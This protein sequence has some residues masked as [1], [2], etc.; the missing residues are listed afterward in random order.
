MV[1]TLVA[2]GLRRN[3]RKGSRKSS[4]CE[5]CLGAVPRDSPPLGSVE[6][7]LAFRVRIDDLLSYHSRPEAPIPAG[8]P[9]KMV[10]RRRDQFVASREQLACHFI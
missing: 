3:S 9:E 1:L 6:E 7:H 8:A 5:R 4:P 2:G 10:G